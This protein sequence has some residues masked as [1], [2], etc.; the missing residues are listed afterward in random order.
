MTL[1][2]V[3]SR[4]V[5]Q[6]SPRGAPDGATSNPLA[7]LAGTGGVISVA[8]E[9]DRTRISDAG[10]PFTPQA[11]FVDRLITLTSTPPASGAAGTRKFENWTFRIT[12]VDP[13]GNWVELEGCRFEDAGT[14]VN[15]VVHAACDFASASAAFPADEAPAATRTVAGPS[16]YKA[17]HI[18][19]ATNE[20][21][22]RMGWMV[23]G[24]NSATSLRISSTFPNNMNT[25]PAETNLEWF[26]RDPP[27][28]TEEQVYKRMHQCL[29]TAGYQVYQFRGRN[30][31]VGAGRFV[32]H[33]IIYLSTGEDGRKRQFLRMAAYNRGNSTFGP[34]PGGIDSQGHK[35]I[36]LAWF[37]A[38][39]RDFVNGAGVNPGNGI[40]PT[41]DHD[42]TT[43][44]GNWAAAADSLNSANTDLGISPSTPNNSALGF[45]V[46]WGS[47]NHATPANQSSRENEFGT[48]AGGDSVE[49][50]IVFL[51]DLEGGIF[52]LMTEGFGHSFI[53]FGNLAPRP[54]AQET[55]MAINDAV[56][57]GVN[58][59]L[60]VGGSP[61]SLTDDGVNPQSPP[62]GPAYRVG[63]RIQIVGQTVNPGITPATSDSGERIESSII[64]SFPGLR[65]AR[66]QIG[67]VATA[68][69]SAGET[70]TVDD[71]QGNVDI[72]EWR[73][74]GGAASGGNIAVDLTGLVTAD[75][76]R[77]QFI[78]VATA[79]GTAN[80]AVSNGGAGLVDL[81]HGTAGGV[82]NVALANSVSDPGYTNV[83]MRGGGYSVVVNQLLNDYGVGALVGEDPQGQYF[84]RFPHEAAHFT[85]E[86]SFILS[87]RAN[88]GDATYRDHN[89]PAAAA[90]GFEAYAVPGPLDAFAGVAPNRATGR[91]TFF[92]LTA[93]D[94]TGAAL[95]GDARH[96]RV[97][98]A[99]LAA[100]RH[101]PDPNNQY[102]LTLPVLTRS[103]ATNST[104]AEIA[105]NP[106]AMRI[107]LGPMPAGMVGL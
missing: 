25:F 53:S 104:G 8:S 85:A 78:S 86:G 5:F 75:Q 98:G 64:Q 45:Y 83:G 81:L 39:D 32:V 10:N 35:G 72:Y 102:W 80:I 73:P 105:L 66:G 28:L 37:S 82:G 9:T 47:P 7:R 44:N 74:A 97:G 18:R 30:D 91:H 26:F 14:G 46:N 31:G 60:R 68:N 27:A 95:R 71:G 43:A 101:T 2:Y 56:T 87:N 11:D 88:F 55:I 62:S 42:G 67:V 29:L 58:V 100:F 12:A 13:G 69:L 92:P 22:N 4:H 3:N 21:L 89:G 20:E 19:G 77:D 16:Q 90:C 38:W 41:K 61:S 107:A 70:Q 106:V 79:S 34:N 1:T 65:A 76:V 103:M 59:E 17:I 84:L 36:D 24:R 94:P 63:D 50:D 52:Y 51:G 23:T 40:N 49:V 54:G 6:R 93:S 57:N 96:I 33:D 99:R 15:Y 48:P